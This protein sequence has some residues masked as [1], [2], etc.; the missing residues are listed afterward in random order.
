MICGTN[1]LLTILEAA[2]EMNMMKKALP[3]CKDRWGVLSLCNNVKDCGVAWVH[4]VQVC[5]YPY[6]V[7]V[8]NSY[9]LLVLRG[10]LHTSPFVGRF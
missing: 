5:I 3:I 2:D 6:L 1:K 9:K 10:W 7:G 4:T 8:Y